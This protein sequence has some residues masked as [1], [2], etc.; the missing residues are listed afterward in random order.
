[1]KQAIIR[2]NVDSV[3]C[4][5]MVLPG[6]DKLT[7]VVLYR[8]AVDTVKRQWALSHDWVTN[9]LLKSIA[10]TLFVWQN[11]NKRNWY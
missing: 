4:S 10:Q 7:M 6:H 5:H 2:A 11:D 3:P 9:K 1:M 8:E